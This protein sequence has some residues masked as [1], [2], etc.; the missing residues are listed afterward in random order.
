MNTFR[1]LL[2]AMCGVASLAGCTALPGQPHEDNEVLA[3][4]AVVDFA[5]LY[6]QNCAGCHGPE[7]RGGAAIALANPVYLR[8]ADD[9][10]IRSV[11]S[12]GVPKTAMPAFAQDAGGLLT[13]A[14]IDVLVAEIRRRWGKPDTLAG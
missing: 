9:V 12:R 14:Q 2:L 8:I 5:T 10:T 11:I 6:G 4:A 13:A 3:P 1:N 7:W